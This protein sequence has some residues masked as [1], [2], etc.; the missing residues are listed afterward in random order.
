[1]TQTL[2]VRNHMGRRLKKYTMTITA[3]GGETSL[4]FANIIPGTAGVPAGAV[5]AHSVR[6]PQ[7]SGT[8]FI[9]SVYQNDYGAASPSTNGFDVWVQTTSALAGDYTATCTVIA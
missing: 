2:N 5:V 3:A 9:S 4:R 8:E 6:G 1:M 7:G